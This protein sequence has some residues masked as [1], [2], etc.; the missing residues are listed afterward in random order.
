VCC[1]S[2]QKWDRRC[3]VWVKSGKPQNEHI[4]SGLPPKPAA[5]PQARA[6][7]TKRSR[8]CRIALQEEG[9]VASGSA[10]SGALASGALTEAD[11]VA[12]GSA[13]L[14]TLADGALLEHGDVATADADVITF[15]HAAL[16]EADDTAQGEAEQNDDDAV[17][18]MLQHD[19]DTRLHLA[20]LIAQIARDIEIEQ[21][22]AEAGVTDAQVAI[23]SR[24][25][26]ELAELGA[27][28]ARYRE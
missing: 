24:L 11:D 12:Q 2:Q 15:A 17:L 3:P 7:S 4:F 1:A 13:Q 16:A 26:G 21:A 25:G 27:F 19:H 10:Q 20:G 23:L 9:D 14:G 8:P 22:L 28:A 18:A 6:P 5:A